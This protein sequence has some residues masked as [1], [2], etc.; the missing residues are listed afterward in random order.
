MKTE[1]TNLEKNELTERIARWAVSLKIGGLVAFLLETNRPIAPLSANVCIGV[2][3]MLDGFA[4]FSI[5][6]LGLFL[7]DDQAVCG[8]RDRILKLQDEAP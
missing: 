4:P 1:L 7:Q 6:A 8:L 3:P 5:G 2:G